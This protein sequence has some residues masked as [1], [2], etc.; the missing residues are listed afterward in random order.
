MTRRD[1]RRP[2]RKARS[3]GLLG[4]SLLALVIVI[5]A[6]I[7]YISKQNAAMD[8]ARLIRR[9]GKDKETLQDRRQVLAAR[10]ALLAKSER[11]HRLASQQLGMICPS[12]PG[13]HLRSARLAAAD[14]A[15]HPGKRGIA[16]LAGAVIGR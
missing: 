6:M 11:V 5:L 10:V 16:V 8:Q 15:A 3:T 1:A 12:T 4:K 13:T 2:G 9:L 7:G 14:P